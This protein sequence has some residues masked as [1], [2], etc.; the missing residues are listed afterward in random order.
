MNSLVE[1]LKKLTINLL[2]I[3]IITCAATIILLTHNAI[4]TPIGHNTSYNMF[5]SYFFSDQL[6]SGELYPRW[7]LGDNNQ[8]GSP[9][10][11]FYAPL[12]FYLSSI[13][14]LPFNHEVNLDIT[15]WISWS[16]FLL[17]GLAFNYFIRS[18][19]NN[20]LAIVFSV[21]YLWLP[22]HY[23]DIE[24]RSAIGESFSYIW[25][26]IILKWIGP[27]QNLRHTI[28]A[29]IAYAGLILSHVPSALL[30]A[31]VILIFMVAISTQTHW[32]RSVLHAGVVGLIGCG[33][34]AFYLLPAL[35]L[36]D[37]LIPNAWTTGSGRFYQA[38]NWLIGNP[39]GIPEF[40][41]MSYT[42]LGITS[43]IAICSLFLAK[44][45]IRLQKTSHENIKLSSS[46]ITAC[47]FTLLFCWLMFSNASSPI[48]ESIAIL[49]QVQ[50]PWRLGVVVDFC[51]L[52]ITATTLPVALKLLIKKHTSYTTAIK[53]RYIFLILP[54]FP[55]SDIAYLFP[56][57]TSRN[58]KISSYT[59]IEYR[60]KWMI[61][62]TAYFPDGYMNRLTDLSDTRSLHRDG[63]E[64]WKNTVRSLP[65]IKSSRVLMD[66]EV[67]ALHNSH[68]YTA[69]NS[70]L[71]DAA[72]ITIKMLY[73]PHWR[74]LDSSGVSI[75]LN[76]D[77]KTGLIQFKLHAGVN[78]LTLVRKLLPSELIGLYISLFFIVSSIVAI[79]I[80]RRRES[81]FATRLLLKS[82]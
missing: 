21:I 27:H 30:A 61:E 8:M 11:Y 57:N 50:F 49:K 22:Y 60:P 36:Q 47:L 16:L 76:P 32:L 66:D 46:L 78:H 5:W 55:L 77:Q 12:P 10:F 39:N 45:A 53:R 75:E 52:V 38:G 59:P 72:T 19:V 73:F 64:R 54:I 35:L 40:G 65:L 34:S 29:G 3:V 63:F 1:Y 17:S 28:Y 2:P 62:S 68:K 15:S 23:I 25:L 69:I 74:L 18:Y 37:N 58:T 33:I 31:P 42:I 81:K 67:L 4:G 56:D 41:A 9:V 44:V 6:F 7:L 82:K 48:W 24:V 80:M 14:Y 26:P 20:Y 51:S 13:F 43:I 70:Q 71:S 79:A